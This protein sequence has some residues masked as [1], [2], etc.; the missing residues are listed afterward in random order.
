M[1]FLVWE[2]VIQR[3]TVYNAGLRPA[4][5]ETLQRFIHTMRALHQE[6]TSSWQGKPCHLAWAE[7][8]IPIGMAV[9]G[10]RAFRLAGQ[11]AVFVRDS[12]GLQD[13]QIAQAKQY[14]QEGAG[15]AKPAPESQVVGSRDRGVVRRRGRRD[16]R[17]R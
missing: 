1:P 13:D 9:S 5:L 2:P 6:G 14:L 10:P 16:G 3:S 15:L 11:L 7:R 17:M 4:R 8:R 12:F